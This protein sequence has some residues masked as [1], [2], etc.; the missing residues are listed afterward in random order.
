MAQAIQPRLTSLFAQDR[1]QEFASLYRSSGRF[2]TALTAGLAGTVA[3]QPNLVLF[4]WLGNTTSGI[5]LNLTLS[6]YAAG[7]G[8]SAYLIVPYL[9]QY[10]H[11]SIRWHIV[12]T[13]LFGGFWIPATIW[14]A[15]RY[16]YVGTGVVWA[17]GNTLYLLLWVPLIHHRLLTLE[18]RHS[19]RKDRILQ[20]GVLGSLLALSALI[21]P[22]VATQLEAFAILAV[23][24]TLVTALGALSSSDLRRYLSQIISYN[25]LRVSRLLTGRP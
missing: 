24:A 25:R 18:E 12:G 22:L 11:G 6:L 17:A 9:M 8:I 21:R 2:I 1:R 13:V 19:L 7:A 15:Y 10:A 4:A 14:A 20:L 5:D 3:V 23:T 16:G